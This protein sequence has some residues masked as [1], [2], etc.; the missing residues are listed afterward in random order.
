M[1][2]IVIFYY[3]TRTCC[4]LQIAHYTS[5]PSYSGV[6]SRT[7]NV[8]RPVHKQRPF[9]SSFCF[10]IIFEKAV[11]QSSVPSQ[12][13]QA[14]DSCVKTESN[15]ECDRYLRKARRQ[16]LTVFFFFFFWFSFGKLQLRTWQ[17]RWYY[18]TKQTPFSFEEILVQH[19]LPGRLIRSD[20]IWR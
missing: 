8:T 16:D 13:N 3:L 20:E 14:Y 2:L 19:W 6:I 10:C 15:I 5:L 9:F 17:A 11:P 4:F 18:N 7:L 1:H 12:R